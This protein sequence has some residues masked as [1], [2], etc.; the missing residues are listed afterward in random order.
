MGVFSR[1]EIVLNV[2]EVYVINDVHVRVIFPLYR[3]A[4]DVS[5]DSRYVEI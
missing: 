4:W 3:W 2:F 1:E 5:G